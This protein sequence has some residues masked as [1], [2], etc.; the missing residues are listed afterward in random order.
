M[1]EGVKKM[2]PRACASR[3]ITWFFG[4][5]WSAG[6]AWAAVVIALAAILAWFFIFSPYGAPAAPVYAEF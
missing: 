5:S 2:A 4:D 1:R 3:V 6:L